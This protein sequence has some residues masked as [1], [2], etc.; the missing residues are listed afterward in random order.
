MKRGRKSIFNNVETDGEL[1]ETMVFGGELDQGQDR[2]STYEQA[3][4]MHKTMRDRVK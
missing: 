2:C 4:K 1:F 3:L